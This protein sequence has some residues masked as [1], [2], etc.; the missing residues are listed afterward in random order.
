[1]AHWSSVEKDFAKDWPL[2]YLISVAIGGVLFTVSDLGLIYIEGAA[3]S[4]P[5][6]ER[7]QQFLL[8]T[9]LFI[10][11]TVIGLEI[12]CLLPAYLI[13]RFLRFINA[14]FFLTCVV[15]G[16]LVGCLV[17]YIWVTLYIRNFD[18]SA[19]RYNFVFIFMA[20]AGLLAGW[21]FAVIVRTRCRSRARQSIEF[22]NTRIRI[23]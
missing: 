23:R 15:T 10:I 17:A 13:A 11:P 5:L 1:M 2:A 9:V 22:P 3:S 8:E 7:L 14:P 12:V 20:G 18:M 4:Y 16:G 19:E 6:T 21:L